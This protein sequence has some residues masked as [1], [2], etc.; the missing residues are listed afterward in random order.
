MLM[1]DYTHR[2]LLILV[3][4]KQCIVT[5]AYNSSRGFFLISSIRKKEKKL[6]G[7]RLKS[8]REMFYLSGF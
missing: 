1:H 3:Y 7:A 5:W 8:N 4:F 2:M 6:P